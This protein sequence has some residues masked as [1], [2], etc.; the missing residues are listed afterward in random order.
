VAGKGTNALNGTELPS[1]GEE[2]LFREVG[3]ETIDVYVRRALDAAV[4]SCRAYLP[5]N[6]IQGRS[7]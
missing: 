2:L 1:H 6:L 7:T 5:R 4:G 3:R